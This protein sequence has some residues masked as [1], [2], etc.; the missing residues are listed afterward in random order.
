MSQD[1]VTSGN[2]ETPSKVESAEF[3]SKKAY[4]DVSKDMHKYKSKLKE[5]EA[6]VNEYQTKFKSVE[7][8]KLAE[9]NRYKELYEKKTQELEVEKTRTVEQQNKYLRSLK[10]VELKRELGGTV[11]DEYLV[12]ADVNGIEFN[13][14]GTLNRDTLV[15]VAN[16]FRQQH[17]ALIP[18]SENTNIT[19][20]AATSGGVVAPDKNIN[21]MT[22][23]EKALYLKNLKK[24]Q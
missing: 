15:T 23:E 5:L 11:K 9:Q 16:K 3:V 2:T 24:Q 4:E 12:H 14:D 6:T 13:E 18:K 8:E 20:H 21:Q 22:F 1:Q 7:E 19:G 17:G 10:V